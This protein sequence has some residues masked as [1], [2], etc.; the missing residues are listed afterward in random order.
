LTIESTSMTWMLKTTTLMSSEWI[1]LK[2]VQ[3]QK[4]LVRCEIRV[5][6]AFVGELFGFY[7][8][9]SSLWS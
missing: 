6:R 4:S 8:G 7:A 1:L 9:A 5:C 3:P 2:M